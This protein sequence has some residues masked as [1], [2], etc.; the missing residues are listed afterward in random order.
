[1]ATTT[2]D[3]QRLL[4]D[5][6]ENAVLNGKTLREELRAN[7]RSVGALLSGGS[8]ASVSKNSSSQSYAYGGGNLTTADVARAW[9]DLI[10]CFDGSKAA[11]IAA[12][13]TDPSDDLVASE[14][15]ERIQPEYAA[16]LDMTSLRL[17]KAFRADAFPINA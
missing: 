2:H 6:R 7:E 3:L 5:A 17:S 16:T 11:L 9:R 12:G 1:M 10:N 14:M 8:L 15:V 4:D 13:E